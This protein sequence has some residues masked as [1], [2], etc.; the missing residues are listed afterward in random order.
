M[1]DL[2]LTVQEFVRVVKI[3]TGSFHSILT[4]VLRHLYDAVQKRRGFR[5][6]FSLVF[7]MS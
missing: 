6:R 5:R 7:L 3:S 2:C 1:G 4:E